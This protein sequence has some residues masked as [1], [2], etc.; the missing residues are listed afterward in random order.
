VRKPA[1][2]AFD[3]QLYKAAKA[4]RWQ[5]RWSFVSDVSVG[6]VEALPTFQLTADRSIRFMKMTITW[7]W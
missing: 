5:R 6:E 3:F 7:L 1:S 2:Q 4:K